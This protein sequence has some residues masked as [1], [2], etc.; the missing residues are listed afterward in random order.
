[1]PKAEQ[2]SQVYHFAVRWSA[3][4]SA[5]TK[6][7]FHR[8]VRGTAD[9]FV[10]QAECT[11]SAEGKANPHYQGYFHTT[12]KHRAKALAIAANVEMSGV[13]I[14]PS[15]TAGIEALRTYCLKETSR[16]AGPWA[17]KKIYLGADLWPLERMPAWQRTLL[18]IVAMKPND[19]T[20]YWIYD[21]VGN[22]GKTKFLK[23]LVYRHDGVG[24]GY[25]HSTDVLNLVSK[26][27]GKN[28]YCW[29]LTRAKPANLSELDLYSAMESVKDGF[30]INLK[31]ETRQVLMDPPHV[32]VLANHLPKYDQI[33]ADRWVVY[34]IEQGKLVLVHL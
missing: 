1:M 13:E 25:G 14:S 18:D 8:W 23:T 17:D 19:R 15:S 28:V 27:P 12:A 16:V 21:P 3:V 29:N 4:F 6:E 33:S 11:T 30:F 5:D 31:Y 22:N 34:L 32:L 7:V 10:Y 2:K 26:L 9:K 20:M 24:L